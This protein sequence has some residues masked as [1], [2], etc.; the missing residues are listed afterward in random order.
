MRFERKPSTRRLST[1]TPEA[2]LKV[3]IVGGSI[4][5][6]QVVESHVW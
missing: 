5:A 1:H 6:P 4:G 2:V 3:R